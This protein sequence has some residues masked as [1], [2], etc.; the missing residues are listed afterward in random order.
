M[1][2]HGAIAVNTSTVNATIPKTSDCTQS[3]LINCSW[4]AHPSR[5]GSTSAGTESFWYPL[6]P[7][8]AHHGPPFAC[9]SKWA[10]PHSGCSA[11]LWSLVSERKRNSL[12]LLGLLT[13]DSGAVH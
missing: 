7:G 1:P 13:G 11:A 5:L 9:C 6:H 12:V 4:Y 3:A 2:Q 8:A 10:F